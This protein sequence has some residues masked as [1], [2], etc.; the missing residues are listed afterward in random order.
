MELVEIWKQKDELLQ[1]FQSLCKF[2]IIQLIM[3]KMAYENSFAYDDVSNV[4]NLSIKGYRPI[5]KIIYKNDDIWY[6]Y[7]KDGNFIMN[8]SRA[9]NVPEYDLTKDNDVK[10]F[11][12]DV[13]IRLLDALIDNK[14]CF[15]KY[16]MYYVVN[17]FTKLYKL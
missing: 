2:R 10:R 12:I 11:N 4:G 5:A 15:S 16:T 14:V 7:R 3:D 17:N 1:K 9:E 8:T 13:R 6:L